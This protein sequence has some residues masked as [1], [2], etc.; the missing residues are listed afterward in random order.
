MPTWIFSS[1][2]FILVAADHRGIF[3]IMFLLA[4]IVVFVSH[5]KFNTSV[6]TAASWIGLYLLTA[7]TVG[8]VY[9]AL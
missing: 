4:A 9:A 5:R 3:P 1:L 6:Q 7:S 8:V 2:V